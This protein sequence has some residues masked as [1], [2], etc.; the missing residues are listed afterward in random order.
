MI[1]YAVQLRLISSRISSCSRKSGRLARAT[2]ISLAMV[3]A[4]DSCGGGGGGSGSTNPPPPPSPVSGPAW[5]GY[6]RDAQHSDLGLTLAQ[7]GVAAQNLTQ[8][9]W[10]ASV[11]LSPP[12]S[13]TTAI[14]YGSPAITSSNTVVVPVKTTAT[15][16][17]RIDAKAGSNGAMLWSAVS[18]YIL[19]AHDWIPSFGITLTPQNRVYMPGSGGKIFYRDNPDSTSG[20]LQTLVFYG[21][22]TYSSASANFDSNVFINTPITSDAAGNIFFGFLVNG[23]NPAGLTSGIARIGAD[24][25]GTWVAANVAAN[26]TGAVSTAMNS[27][28]AISND[29]KTLYVA[30]KTIPASGTS[31]GYLLAL[32][33]TT[34]A[35]KSRVALNDP[36]T[37]AP[38]T[39]SDNSTASP[40]VGP[41]GD[42]YF[43]VLESVTPAHDDR[44]WLLHFDSTLS[45]SKTIGAFG[46]D[47]TPSIVPAGMVPSYTGK[48]TYLL[49]S[50]YNN[51]A[52]FPIGDG[53]NRMAILDP[54]QT[55]PDP[56]LGNPVMKEVMTLLGQTSDP[57]FPNNPG[58]VKE[59]CVNSAAVDPITDSIFVNSEDGFLYR[60][61]L[62]T[63][64]I[65]Q[66]IWL[67]SGYG[68]AYTPTALG[69]DGTVYS[70]NAGTLIAVRN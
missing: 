28:P 60:W 18:D 7:G 33:S 30:V 46:W 31:V 38:A 6:A 21:A 40:V 19:P 27:A 55:E 29:T 50:K 14:H 68:Q 15:G 11:D 32:D 61:N 43:G 69:P 25:T 45:L 8:I 52:D 5:N 57:N 58:A 41:D 48:S 59:W 10:E 56:L 66:K 26:Q 12:N 20:T 51:Y 23:T 53:K 39:I 17:F 37:G 44:G 1:S 70:I 65:S 9:A 54:N 13:A 42:V 47:D 22:S 34:L 3:S 2:I 49:L 16:N 63:G 24:G 35:T 62:S 67:D 36:S 64:N 4:L